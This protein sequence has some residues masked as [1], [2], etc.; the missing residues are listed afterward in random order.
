VT[1]DRFN[2]VAESNE[3]NNATSKRVLCVP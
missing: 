1:I 2:A 3:Q